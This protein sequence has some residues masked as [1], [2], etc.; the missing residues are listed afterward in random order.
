[1]DNQR[2]PDWA[3]FYRNRT[4]FVTGHTGF[5]GSWLCEWL[6]ALGAKVTGFSQPPETEPALFHQLQ[7]ADRIDHQIG[8]IRDA[9]AL[10]RSL[11]AAD[12]DIIFHL[13]AQPLVR[14]SYLKPDETHE[15][16]FLGTVRL[17]ELL[18]K[19]FRPCAALVVTSDK[20][21]E[22][23]GLAHGY[24]EN[25][26][27]GGH[28]PYSS[29]KACAELVVSSYRR[30][31]FNG[32]NGNPSSVRI[33]S[34]RAGNVIGGGDWSED[35]IVPDCIR[36]LLK[37]EPIGVRNRHAVRP[38]Q[39]VLE[40]LS[41]YLL[42]AA[43]IHPD[44]N[45]IPPE[46]L[47]EFDAFNFGPLHDSERSVKELVEEILLHWPGE[48]NDSTPEFAPHE[49]ELLTLNV[50]KA[51][52]LLG[53]QPRWSFSETVARTVRWYQQA[54]EEN[55][56][57]LANLTRAQ[58]DDYTTLC[59]NPNKRRKMLKRRNRTRRNKASLIK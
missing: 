31:F 53:W 59:F 39:H 10:G 56:T 22:N 24:S 46:N 6:L 11:T 25:D 35:R 33:A 34:A 58:I 20:C 48:W 54:N 2:I 42:L 1:M 49:A 40:P 19:R 30:S 47:H 51:Q 29:S 17:L 14:R 12:P 32:H 36:S 13:A 15:I 27:L 38:W 52:R 43:T 55:P 57:A 21:Y 16:N 7:L 9:D 3:A 37:N 45:T 44:S 8:D 41:G 50:S 23:I 26:K 5:K 4:V 28:D 18:R